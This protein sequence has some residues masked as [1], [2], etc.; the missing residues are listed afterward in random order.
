MG[1]KLFVGTKDQHSNL[2]TKYSSWRNKDING[3]EVVTGKPGGEEEGFL[4]FDPANPD[5]SVYS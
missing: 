3:N 4:F 5:A 1:R 2:W